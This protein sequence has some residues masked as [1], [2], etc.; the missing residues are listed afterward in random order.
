MK[1]ISDSVNKENKPIIDIIKTKAINYNS[2]SFLRGL[3]K[4]NEKNERMTEM[5]KPDYEKMYRRY[6]I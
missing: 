2:K 3:K 1:E 6:N 4:V 5:S